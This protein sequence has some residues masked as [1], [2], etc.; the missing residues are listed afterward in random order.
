MKT[1]WRKPKTT[2]ANQLIS[3]ITQTN[4]RS[5]QI[6]FIKMGESAILTNI[7]LKQ[8]IKRKASFI[9]LTEIF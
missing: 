4:K 5:K 9:T 1:P 7:T 6:L 2:K 8:V 3:N